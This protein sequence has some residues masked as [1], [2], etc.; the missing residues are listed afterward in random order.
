VR[1][2]ETELLTRILKNV[3]SVQNENAP[4]VEIIVSRANTPILRPEYWQES[5][6]T[7]DTTAT[8]TSVAV[9]KTG[10]KITDVYVSYVAGGV[11][12]IKKAAFLLPITRMV[13]ETVDTVDGAV[14]C[15]IEFDGT[16]RKIER[17]VEFRTGDTPCLFYTTSAG[18]LMYGLV[19]AET[20][21]PLVASGVSNLDA[22]MG[23]ESRYGEISQGLICFYIIAGAVYYRQLIDGVW[24]GQETVAIAPVNAV[25]VKAERLFD[26][27][28]VLHVTD[29]TGALYEVFSKM[30]ASGW[31]SQDFICAAIGVVSSSIS[32]NY[33]DRYESIRISAAVETISASLYA[34]SPI[35]ISAVNIDDGFGDYGYKVLVTF[36]ERIYDVD[37]G[38]AMT[39]TASGAWPSLSVVKISD[40][41]VEVTFANFNN[42]TGDCTVVYTPGEM[43]GDIVAVEADS[44]IFMPTGLIPFATDPPAPVIIEN[45]EDW[46]GSI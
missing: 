33:P 9:K 46:S 19:G 39:D 11:L 22:V 43:M 31:N 14:E 24:Q 38:F 23:V 44:I 15:A 16:F 8:C 6:V 45:I 13:W 29:N 18:A 2:I 26:Y 40:T 7:A 12:T 17:N 3:Q 20:Y 41:V 42:A 21:E 4:S 27:R 25:S 30:E 34:L 36:D 35:M 10:R 5:V 1:E 37:T 32:I 28:I